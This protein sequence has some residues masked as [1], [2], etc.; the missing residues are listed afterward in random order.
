PLYAKEATWRR[1]HT[2]PA[3]FPTRDFETGKQLGAFDLNLVRGLDRH[4][5]PSVDS[6]EFLIS[7]MRPILAVSRHDFDDEA[8]FHDSQVFDLYED[9]FP[10]ARERDDREDIIRWVLRSDLGLTRRV[11]LS[12]TE[13]IEYTL[14]SRYFIM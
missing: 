4:T 14:D 12:N 3:Q 5:N 6:H 2:L 1:T 7:E 13:T 8:K 9:L 10:D 11:K